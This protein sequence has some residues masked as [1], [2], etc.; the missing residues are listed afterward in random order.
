MM[1][2]MAA[3]HHPRA[4]VP[5]I[6][7]SRKG[8]DNVCRELSALVSYDTTKGEEYRRLCLVDYR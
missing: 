7:S 2:Y 3:V 1:H 4:S 6:L 8:E 5:R